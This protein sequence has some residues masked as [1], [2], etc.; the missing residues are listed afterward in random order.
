MKKIAIYIVLFFPIVAC[1]QVKNVRL[2][3]GGGSSLHGT[4]DLKGYSFL[5]QVELKLKNNFFLSSGLQLTNN[6]Q[7]SNLT[8]FSL[9]YVTA[10]ANIFANINYS[11][12]NRNRHQVAIGAGPLLRFQNSSVPSEVGT[13]LSSSGEQILFIKYDKLRTISIGYNISPSYYYQLSQK[14]SLGAKFILQNDTNSDMLTSELVFVGFK[15]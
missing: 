2:I 15:L 14:V 6:S 11:V 7:R 4:G 1:S 3:I 5:N 13:N 10:G 12:I 8:Y 9:N